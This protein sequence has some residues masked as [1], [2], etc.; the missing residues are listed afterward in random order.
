[1]LAYFNFVSAYPGRRHLKKTT[2]SR[3]AGCKMVIDCKDGKCLNYPQQLYDMVTTDGS[4][5]L[6]S[7]DNIK[8][9]YC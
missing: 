2:C 8:T 5:K 4:I 7:R 1:M 6:T 9:E 3:N